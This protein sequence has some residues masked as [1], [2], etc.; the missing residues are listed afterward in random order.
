M[1]QYKIENNLEEISYGDMLKLL[2][3][4]VLTIMELIENKYRVLEQADL[5]AVKRKQDER[6]QHLKRILE[7]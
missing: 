5:E 1:I 3:K 4:Y 7:K 6:R 2:K